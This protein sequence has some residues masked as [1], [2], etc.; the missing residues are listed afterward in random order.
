MDVDPSSKYWLCNTRSAVNRKKELPFQAALT[1]F[2]YFIK[3][4]R[5]LH[6]L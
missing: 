1:L 4:I 5:Y 6:P 3:M 2:R